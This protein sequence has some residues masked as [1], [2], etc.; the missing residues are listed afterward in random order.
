MLRCATEA[1]FPRLVELGRA[2]HAEG[3]YASMPFDPEVLTRTLAFV[4]KSGFICVN[5]AAGHIDAVMVAV[6]SPS[7]FGPGQ[8]VSDL[9][10][11]VEP[12]ARG[13]T[14]AYRLIEAFVRWAESKKVHAMYLGVTTG[15]HP[16]QTGR[17]Y[18][19]LGF[20]P[21][22]GLYMRK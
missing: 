21:V 7:W 12:A 14:V 6:I 20:Q 17:L 22:G 4:R 1:D 10:L 9:A 2:M 16:E 11:F 19:R 15:V 8:T 5:E 13:G 3:S 18:E